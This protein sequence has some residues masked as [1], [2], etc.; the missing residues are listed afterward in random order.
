MPEFKSRINYVFQYMIHL[1][2]GTT[3]L[4]REMYVDFPKMK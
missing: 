1:G 4:D 3:I 2:R